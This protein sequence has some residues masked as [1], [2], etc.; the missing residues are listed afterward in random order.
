AFFKTDKGMSKAY[1]SSLIHT[2]EKFITNHALIVDGSKI[3]HILPINEI[4]EG[5]ERE[6]LSEVI[7]PGLTDL[8][9]YGGGGVLFSADLTK[10][11][12][13][14]MTQG[15]IATGTT[16]F[17]V[18]LATNS[19]EVFNKAIEIIKANPHPSR[20]GIHF[21]GPYLNPAKKGAHVEKYIHPP[22]LKEVKE[23]INRGEGVIKMIT[24]APEICPPEVIDY[25]LEQGIILSAGHSNASYDEAMA[26]FDRGIQTATHLFNAMSSFHHRDPGLPGAIYN[27]SVAM[28]S[29]IPDG[30]HVNFATVEISS[31]IMGYRLFLITDAV[32]ETS[33]GPYLH[34]KAE[35]R[36]T[37]PDG[38]LSG[39]AISML[40]GVR[41]CIEFCNIPRDAAVRMGSSLP[42]SLLKNNPAGSLT[43]GNR[44][45]FLILDRNFNLLKTYFAG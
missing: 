36:F 16:T 4:P 32:E 15:I 12:L 29:I 27:H 3:S 5:M 10:E 6:N 41:N 37:L 18:T 17:L 38:T 11:G 39:S 21:E 20:P 42:G 31:K 28:A 8:Q 7:I 30:I 25:L 33:T 13:D 35:G 9:I 34:L 1:P 23:F 2:G 14:R 40:Q 44:A 26:G 24:L 22:T 45:D 43:P 19:P